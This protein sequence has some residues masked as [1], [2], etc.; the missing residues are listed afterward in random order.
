MV[1]EGL[2]LEIGNDLAEIVKVTQAI[3]SFC[4]QSGFSREVDY[5]LQLV[6]EELL[7]NI[8]LHGYPTGGPH[9]ITLDIEEKPGEACLVV[10]DDGIPFNIL[11]QAA[12]KKPA[13]LDEFF[14]GGL[15]IPLVRSNVDAIT[16]RFENGWNILVLTKRL[17]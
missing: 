17:N 1:K 10:K 8:I 11:E 2:H 3:H 16:Y 9:R 14:P 7:T 13:S 6:A 12:P 4:E 15:G 5:A